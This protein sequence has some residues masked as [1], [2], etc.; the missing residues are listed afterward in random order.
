MNFKANSKWWV[1]KLLFDFVKLKIKNQVEP[2]Q[3]KNNH[4]YIQNVRM[5]KIKKF[6]WEKIVVLFLDVG[7]LILPKLI[8]N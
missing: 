7:K 8:S 6:D 5:S 4:S 1:L 2:W 3:R